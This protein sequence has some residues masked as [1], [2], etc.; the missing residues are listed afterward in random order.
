MSH[1]ITKFLLKTGLVAPLLL[2]L[3]SCQNSGHIKG[4]PKNL[5]VINLHGSASTPP[6]SMAHKDYPFADNGD[7]KTDW[8]SEG[9]QGAGMDYSSWRTSHGGAATRG[10]RGS[11]GKSGSK[12]KSSGKG[13]SYTIKSGDT[14]GTIARKNGTTVAKLKAANG[15]KSDL[16]RA[17]KTLKIPK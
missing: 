9:G 4:L 8:A 12:S 6:H 7:Y 16:I 11:K 14:L 17:G 5:P 3:A 2:L 13:G 1:P 15:L 10:S